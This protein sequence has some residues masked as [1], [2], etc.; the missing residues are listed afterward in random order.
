MLKSAAC[1]ALIVICA[2]AAPLMAQDAAADAPEITFA[3]G[4]STITESHGDWTLICGVHEAEK[5]CVVTQSLADQQRGQRVLTVEMEAG[6]EGA[7]GA[8]V[9]LPFGLALADGVRM[10]IDDVSLGEASPFT[11]CYDYGCIADFDLDAGSAQLLGR[12]TNL[13]FVGIV[14]DTGENIALSVSL[15]GLTSALERAPAVLAD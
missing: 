1:A 12:G 6:S 11:V 15:N 2:G 3:G 8:T 13:R 5:A 9:V 7:I 4:A 10:Q 14:A